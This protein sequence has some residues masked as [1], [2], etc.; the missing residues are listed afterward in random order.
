MVLLSLMREG[1]TRQHQFIHMGLQWQQHAVVC[2]EFV[3]YTFG[4]FS[5]KQRAQVVSHD[6]MMSLILGGLR[7]PR[8]CGVI[9]MLALFFPVASVV[10]LTERAA[11]L[12]F[13]L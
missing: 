4:T 12:I 1:N 6:Q 11:K 9:E 2:K 5:L 7:D 13:L 8:A 10:F 3:L